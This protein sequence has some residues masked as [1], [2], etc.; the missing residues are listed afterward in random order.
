MA[1]RL[2]NEE[3]ISKCHLQHD[4]KYDYSKTVYKK[5]D[6]KILIICPEHGEFSQRASAHSGKQAQGCREC[7]LENNKRNKVHETLEKAYIAHLDKCDY[8]LVIDPK[9]MRKKV[10]IICPKHGIFEQT[11]DH[12]INRGQGC[13][14]CSKSKDTNDFIKESKDRFGD[15]LDYS[16]VIYKN[17]KQKIILIC[18]KHGEFTQRAIDHLSAQGACPNCQ[19]DLLKNSIND[20]IIRSNIIHNNKYKYNIKN[21]ENNKQKIKITCPKHGDFLQRV[22]S[23][24]HSGYGCSKCNSSKGENKQ[25]IRGY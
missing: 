20:I 15:F 9:S 14:V 16:K 17:N 25:S 4:G 7:Y 23:H 19:N 3:F 1:K 12:H 13:S 5:S 10:K 24:L 8:S 11:L 2:T 22:D 6:D 21:Y 18:P